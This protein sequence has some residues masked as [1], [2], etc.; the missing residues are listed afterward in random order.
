MPAPARIHGLVPG[1]FQTD[2]QGHYT[3]PLSVRLA[4]SLPSPSRLK[5][6]PPDMTSTHAKRPRLSESTP[7]LPPTSS[8][9]RSAP[10]AS[11][12]L[13]TDKP[14]ARS[15]QEQVDKLFANQ[16]SRLGT[17]VQQN[18]SLLDSCSSWDEFAMAVHGPP[19]LQPTVGDLP[20]PAAELLASIHD[21]GVPVLFDDPDWTLEELDAA[22]AQGCN[23]SA[24]EHKEFIADEMLEFGKDGFWTILPY[25]R[26]R[27]LKGLRLSPAQIKEERDR[28]P[29]F[30]ADHKSWGVNDHTVPAAPLESMQ[31]GGALYRLL[32]EIRNANPKH[33]PV[34]MAKY[35]IKDGFYRIHLRPEHCLKLAIILPQYD[36]L[37]PLVAI[38]FVLTMGW[39][40]SP[41][42]FCGFSETTC[43][44]A[45]SR[46]YK[47]HAPP[48]RLEHL[49][50][51]L[52]NISVKAPP[53]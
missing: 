11:P 34:H 15:K 38:P 31:F 45:N 19:H 42:T 7:I 12:A 4:A 1:V 48:H 13:A 36:G 18:C 39:K 26:V 46:L 17:F 3:E 20:H 14:L 28:R 21:H 22:V 32:T 33:G 44:V 16:L 2:S 23:F 41:P 30:I 51:P 25:D 10:V 24:M 9:Q 50:A 29:R 5:R 37:P 6:P 53:S 40:N 47:R 27:G 8:D 52:D 43:D 49:P 35:D